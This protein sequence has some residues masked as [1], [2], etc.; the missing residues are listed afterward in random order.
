MVWGDPTVVKG[1]LNG[2]MLRSDVRS[3]CE[4]GNDKDE[5][6]VLGIL[7]PTSNIRSGT[8]HLLLR[9]PRLLQ[10]GESRPEAGGG[11]GAAVSSKT[12]HIQYL[13][14]IDGL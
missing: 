7:F 11:I 8:I 9:W 13:S 14:S 4:V 10:R 2:E 12:H 3:H 1:C 6:R 5:V